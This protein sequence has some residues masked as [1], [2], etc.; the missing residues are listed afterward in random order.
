MPKVTLVGAT[1]VVSVA[2]VAA[3]AV[4]LPLRALV[5]SS[6]A[7][8]DTPPALLVLDYAFDAIMLLISLVQLLR[9][10]PHRHRWLELLAFVPFDVAVALAGYEGN[11][12]FFRL[13]H[14]LAIVPLWRNLRIAEGYFW[15]LSVQKRR[16]LYILLILPMASHWCGC[17]WFY[18]AYLER[19]HDHMWI[20]A[21]LH[22]QFYNDSTTRMYLRSVYWGATMLT[23]VGFGDVTAV[24]FPETIYAIMVIYIGIF[25]SCA[26]IASVVKLMEHADRNEMALQEMLD[27][28]CGYLEW[29]GASIELQD[30][31][32]VAAKAAFVPELNATGAELETTLPY[33][34]RSRLQIEREEAILHGV[35]RFH[36]FSKSLRQAISE[37]VVY[38][39][40]APGDV[41]LLAD[42]PL[43][44]LYFLRMGAAEF[45]SSDDAVLRTLRAGDF[46]GD[47]SLF[48]KGDCVPFTVVC[49]APSEFVFLSAR[50]FREVVATEHAVQGLDDDDEMW[51][52]EGDI[53]MQHESS[54]SSARNGR[55]RRCRLNASDYLPNSMFRRVWT[56]LS[57]LGLLYNV[58]AV[59]RDCAFFQSHN[60]FENLDHEAMANLLI[61]WCFDIF[62][63]TDFYLHCTRFAVE[64]DGTIVTERRKIRN[65]FLRS[66]W[67]WVDAVSILPLD[68]L[69]L[70]SGMRDLPFYRL[71]KILRFL[72][73]IEYFQ[74]AEAMLLSRFHIHV[75]AR[76][77]LRILSILVLSGYIVGCFWYYVAQVTSDAY[78]GATWVA[79]DQGN[80][81]YYFQTYAH[82]RL[83]IIRSMYFGYIGGSTLGFG[84]IVPV[85][86]YE[87]LVATIML[88]YGAIIKPALVGSVASLLLTRNKAKLS[89]QKTLIGFKW[90]VTAHKLPK[91]LKERVL[92]YFEFMWD[93]E[94]YEKETAILSVL[95]P[96]RWEIM[97]S[98]C[99]N[100]HPK[101]WFFGHINDDGMRQIYALLEPQLYM[102]HA[103]VSLPEG[104][105]G[106]L[107][108]GTL[109]RASS[110]ER[111]E[112]FEEGSLRLRTFGIECFVQHGMPEADAQALRETH[113]FS[114]ETDDLFCEV[115][116]LRAPGVEAILAPAGQWAPLLRDMLLHL[117][118]DD[119]EA[120]ALSIQTAP[121]PEDATN[122]DGEAPVPAK[123]KPSHVVPS[124]SPKRNS[125][126]RRKRAALKLM[127]KSAAAKEKDLLRSSRFHPKSRFRK[128][129]SVLV[130]L[131]LLYNAFLVP[132]RLAFFSSLQPPS[133]LY[134]FIVDY[135]LD[136]LFVLDVIAKY[137]FKLM[138]LRL[139]G[140]TRRLHWTVF[141]ALKW[142]IVCALPMELCFLGLLAN[143]PDLVVAILTIC[144]LPK[145]VRLR[146][147]VVRIREL[148]NTAVRARPQLND[149]VVACRYFLFILFFSHLLACAWHYLAFADKGILPWSENC[150]LLDNT[151]VN[152]GL[153]PGNVTLRAR[154]LFDGTWIEYQMKGGYLPPDGGTIWERYSRCFNFG[155]Q[156]LLV[157]SSG[158]IVPVNMVETFFCIIAIFAGIFFSAGKIG[159]IGEIALKVDSLSASIRQSTDAL[160]KYME[161]HETPREL[162]DR[163]LGFMEYL[164]RKRNKILFQEEEVVT[165]LPQQLQ[166]D[167]LAH[168]KRDRLSLS[169]LFAS[170]PDDARS[171]VAAAMRH[172]YY[173]PSDVVAT[174]GRHTGAMFFVKPGSCQYLD[175]TIPSSESKRLSA[176]GA[177]SLLFDEP[178]E[179]S[180]CACTFTE[181]YVLR[182]AG[183]ESLDALFPYLRGFLESALATEV[184]V[185]VDATDALSNHVPDDDPDEP[186]LPTAPQSW[187]VPDSHFRRFW[188]AL[189]FWT[190]L[191]VLVMLPLRASYLVETR[192]T[193]LYELT[194]WYLGDVLAI[195]LYALDTYL[196][197]D[198]FVFMDHSKMIFNRMRIRE[199]YRPYLALDFV[200]IGP[201]YLLALH[202]GVPSLK[203]LM[204]P[205]L[206]RAKRFPRYLRRFSRNFQYYFCRLSG[207]VIHILHCIL[208][209][210]VM[211]HWW[212]CI[213]MFLH[214]YVE[215]HSPL[216]W[217][218]RDPYMGGG[219]LSKWNATSQTH[220]ICR[221]MVACYARAYY[222]VISFVGTIGLGDVVTGGHLEYL[223][224]DIE[225]LFGSFFF[226]ALTSCFAT[227]FQFADTYGKGAT[228]AKLSGLA[229][230]FRAA[231]TT[232]PT[233][234]AIVANTKLWCLRSGSL[235]EKS[236]ATLLP[237]PLRIELANHVQRALLETSPFL[238]ASDVYV[239]HK[240]VLA[241]HF[242]V[243]CA[244]ATLYGLGGPL[245]EVAFVHSGELKL[246]EAPSV[247]G[248]VGCHVGAG[249]A[250]A[251]LHTV[252]AVSHLELYVLDANGKADV[253]EAIAAPHRES[254]LASLDA[255]S[256]HH[257]LA[258]AHGGLSRQHAR[259]G[260]SDDEED[261]DEDEDAEN[262]DELPAWLALPQSFFK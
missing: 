223:F 66:G 118:G 26:S 216:T 82:N 202:L 212:A 20:N 186:T 240:L 33:A 52:K 261:E 144:R 89:Q 65:L 74:V 92:M 42:A 250:G 55:R 109:F 189:L 59:P 169:P 142:D 23:T 146:Y 178:Q 87:T 113:A 193:G 125:P 45:R 165:M 14:V 76:R 46:F 103:T 123:Y 159:V 247:R 1:C 85:N 211:V 198:H 81:D 63:A 133:Y 80:D 43:D 104:A 161:F 140:A 86:P 97:R 248:T 184:D 9:R 175:P 150:N 218:V 4:T 13:N 143:R 37:Q 147:F 177:R 251:C 164:Y 127:I 115:L 182:Q 191:Y 224:E 170:V 176:F 237:I 73:L 36:H 50:K 235:V 30:R 48:Q 172:K 259:V 58:Y 246:A 135:V 187:R 71:N 157:V 130:V 257:T 7:L 8:L 84:D 68:A 21:S 41:L 117:H 99:R 31:A 210:V 166:D 190:T 163:A 60:R 167:I 168:C 124:G 77:I 238:Q 255:A 203:F 229:S 180:I 79:M 195:L 56:L 192:F 119:A 114:Y 207:S 197:F 228:Q 83:Y 132:F 28:V 12:G 205:L 160:S 15:R 112:I 227:Y 183:L 141:A 3:N 151:H 96:L 158:I 98:M 29:R 2:A 139:E 244:S 102:P 171:A 174:A 258:H 95:S 194:A 128:V 126:T 209:Y 11:F 138:S 19:H 256:L 222:F 217:A 61:F 154:C 25:V 213:W 106:I 121:M 16:T 136:V 134:G 225:A 49:T 129:L 155:I 252:V 10:S 262:P 5:I 100:G 62:F 122:D 219:A 40:K 239:R 243:V 253:L 69:G 201:Y 93:H 88:L 153:N 204:M 185:A 131:A 18:V 234:R 137:K 111:H 260:A 17:F 54:S 116:L 220:D 199:N 245:D 53:L 230:Y 107:N 22:K 221:S 67:F 179:H 70:V 206:L 181:V 94:Y 196:S 105:L 226:A 249:V 232:K 149:L 120:I 215:V 145:V 35:P 254:F 24:T 162:K 156:M 173:A 233:A 242:Q 214:R 208:Y 32:L 110:N 44:G 152:D 64:H 78:G 34:L 200:T 72:H 39:N 108:T 231:H 57:L 101:A 47:Q 148:A 75:F 188:D 6:R 91:V 241:L 90:L 236:V 51:T 38:V 27:D